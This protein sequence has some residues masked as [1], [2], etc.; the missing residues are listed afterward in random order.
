MKAWHSW[1]RLMTHIL[2]PCSP[3]LLLVSAIGSL[4]VLFALMW[5]A[6]STPLNY[7]LLA[8]FTMLE[9]HLVGTVGK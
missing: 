6:R 1:L 4:G 5:K 2:P 9:G 7:Y 3:W 8:L